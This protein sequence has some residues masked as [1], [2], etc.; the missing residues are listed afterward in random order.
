MKIKKITT[1]CLVIFMAF[2]LVGC[3]NA[4]TST[5]VGLN[6]NKTVNNLNNIIEKLEEVNYSDIIINDI[7]PLSD[8]TYNTV[9]TKYSQK[10][11]WYT[12]GVIGND[13]RKT[14]AKYV[15]SQSIDNNK[16]GLNNTKTYNCPN[17]ECTDTPTTYKPKYTNNVSNSFVRTS[18][19]G[20]IKNIEILYNNCA[21]CISCEAECI[22]A[23]NTLT[24]NINTCKILCN[25]LTDGTIKLSQ[26][27]IS[28]CNDKIRMLESYTNRL[29]NTKGNIKTKVNSVSKIKNN[30]N[31]Q[32]SSVSNAYQNL[33]D[34]LETRLECYNDC[35]KTLCNIQDIINKTNVNVSEALKNKSN[36]N[37]IKNYEENV[38]N[39]NLNNNI[40]NQNNNLTNNNSF[41]KQNINTNN[42][43][44]S[45]K[46]TPPPTL[47]PKEELNNQNYNNVINDV[48]NI[49]NNTNN[50][51]NNL[52]Q[53][54]VQT[55]NLPNSINNPN[56]TPNN[57]VNN[58]SN[59][60]NNFN[61]VNAYNN[62]VYNN[63]P[64]NWT[65]YNGNTYPPRNI[66]TYH[67]INKNIDTYRPQTPIY[68]GTYTNQNTVN[69]NTLTTNN[70]TMQ[71]SKLNNVTNTNINTN[72]NSN[73]LHEKDKLTK[74]ILE[75]Q[76][77]NNDANKP[78]AYPY[79][80]KSNSTNLPNNNKMLHN[81]IENDKIED[82][83]NNYGI[84]TLEEPIIDTMQ[85]DKNAENTDQNN[86]TMQNNSQ[87][88]QL[89][90]DIKSKPKDSEFASN[91]NK[92]DVEDLKVKI[93]EYN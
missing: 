30:Y 17:G 44:Q 27:E 85:T 15:N 31:T 83:E 23:K 52:N 47:I 62:G 21:D 92:K 39:N 59:I 34:A 48:N 22:N 7:N 75:N 69:N 8:N 2:C 49:P 10:S 91:Q 43:Y 79:T 74:E 76:K 53:N 93:K 40:N 60:P 24:Q 86:T 38:T 57:V 78:I 81:N 51:P 13:N 45:T 88:I 42:R 89:T 71:K 77:N 67:N 18:L 19:N 11:K 65:Y 61:N 56:N 63:T 12:V 1:F 37:D 87:N 33:L 5:A 82:T 29:N 64:N 25:K 72:I 3:G 28:S 68:N 14:N 35:N 58:N 6:L 36:L 55:N 66:D 84:R 90:K 50:T 4:K 46:T 54:N 26:S 9:N 32:L 20:Y 70:N 41:V 16:I 80:S 73:K